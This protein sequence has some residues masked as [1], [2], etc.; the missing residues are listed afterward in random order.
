MK[1]LAGVVQ[2]TEYDGNV[3]VLKGLRIGYLPQEPL[4]DAGDTVW[5][6]IAPALADMRD[7]LSQF[8]AVSVAM[9]EPGADMD[10]LMG[11]MERLQTEIDAAN[12]WELD[13]T[14]DRAMEALRC[15]PRDAL[16]ATL[17][18]GE[19]RRVAICRLLLSAPEMLL[20]VRGCDARAHVQLAHALTGRAHEP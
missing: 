13:R 4:L 3:E 9:G 10:A 12:G 11:K 6:N 20:L 2:P 8:E 18:G 15:P 14:A 5:E 19:R 17:S 16:V 1:I 7:K